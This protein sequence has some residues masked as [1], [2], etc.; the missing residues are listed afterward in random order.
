MNEQLFDKQSVNV[1][2]EQ[3]EVYLL[4]YG[5]IRDGELG[6]VATIWHRPEADSSNAEVVLP[7]SQEA[8]DYT[9]RMLDAVFA[10]AAFEGRAAADVVNIVAGYFVDQVSIRVIHE[11]IVKG[12][13]PLNDGVLLNL[14]ARDL[15]A[16]SAMSTLNK[17]KHFSGKRAPEAREFLNGLRLGQTAVGSYI[18]NVLVPLITPLSDQTAIPMSSMTR[19]VTANLAESLGALDQAIVKFAQENDRT[20]FDRAVEIGASANMCDA[21][22]GLSGE[23]RNRD[24]EIAITPSISDEYKN[25]PTKFTFDTDKIDC[26]ALA[27]EYYKDNYVLLDITISGFITRLDRPV[28]DD[29]GTITVGA[30]INSSEKLITVELGADEYLDAISAHKAKNVVECHGD[31]HVRARTAK[32]LHPSAFRIIRTDALF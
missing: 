23:L 7:Q 21:L 25:G 14:R 27:S 4:K 31:V 9:D 28:K 3:L 16:A 20:V 24:F 1:S 29:V 13:I 22:L 2:P 8:K 12:T 11:D 30:T 17:R 32:L 19:M 5:W 6:D 18:V 10:I 26:I 15:L